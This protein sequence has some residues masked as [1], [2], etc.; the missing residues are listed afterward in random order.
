MKMFFSRTRNI[1]LIIVFIL[2][3]LTVLGTVHFA[4]NQENFQFR[5]YL[6]NAFPESYLKILKDVVYPLLRQQVIGVT[7]GKNIDSI[8]LV[9][10]RKDIDHFD[11]LYRKFESG[12][13]IFYNQNIQLMDFHT[14]AH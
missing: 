7:Q 6:K 10:S 2:L 14:F 12:D 5:S 3:T 11:A 9:L 1:I 13:Q 8:K 4:S